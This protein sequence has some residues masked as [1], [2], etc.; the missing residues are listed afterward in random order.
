MSE[1][2]TTNAKG[3]Y[4]GFLDVYVA[5]MT[6]EDT[7]AKKPDYDTPKVLGEGIE[8]TITPTYTEGELNASNRV[9]RRQKK[10]AKYSLKLNVA[11]LPHELRNYVLGR[12]A[13]DNGVELLDG[14][15]QMPKVAIGLGRTKDNGAKELWWLY[16]CQFAEPE[17]TAK[18]EQEGQVEYQTPNLE[19]TADRRI[20]DGLL[21]V[22][23]DSDDENLT[24]SVVTGWFGAVYES[25]AKA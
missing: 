4:T 16:A 1:V 9:I 18:T 22:V 23:A 10:V 12:Q 7:A 17:V 5:K 11:T 25:P 15:A 21:G 19:A 20:F 8:V 13:D 24:E 14:G 3:I 2:V 6:T